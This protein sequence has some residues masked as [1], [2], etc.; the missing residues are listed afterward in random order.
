[1]A[2]SVMIVEDERRILRYIRNKL[3]GYAEFDVCGCF[4]DPEQALS[5]FGELQPEVA[6]LD[7]RMPRMTGVELAERLLV[8]KPD[9]R[10]VF[11][12]AYEHSATESLRGR[13]IDSIFKPVV[14]EDIQRVIRLLGPTFPEST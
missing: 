14:G 11:M 10:I 2:Y 1:M 6:F 8:I 12:T 5:A 4:D 13:V 7:I 3:A 9:I